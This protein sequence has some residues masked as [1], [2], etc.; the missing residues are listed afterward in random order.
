MPTRETELAELTRDYTTIRSC[1]RAC[2]AERRIE[3]VGQLER[4][5]IMSS[6][7]LDTAR[8][9]EK[10]IIRI[11]RIDLLGALVERCCAAFVAAEY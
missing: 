4:R 6:S 2:S 9:A 3:D 10:P 5:Q 11:L 8:I 7:A 1:I